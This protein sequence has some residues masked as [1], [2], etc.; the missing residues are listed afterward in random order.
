[1]NNCKNFG[2]LP[3]NLEGLNLTQ[4]IGGSRKLDIYTIAI[5]LNY[6]VLKI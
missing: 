1:M 6:Y 4:S 5:E 3:L 2:F